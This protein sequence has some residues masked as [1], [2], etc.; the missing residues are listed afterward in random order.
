MLS[1]MI[2]FYDCLCPTCSCYLPSAHASARSSMRT[3]LVGRKTPLKTAATP[4][5]GGAQTPS[6]ASRQTMR[7]NIPHR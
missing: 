6:T 7:H 3:P 4:A 5:R 1:N 2:V